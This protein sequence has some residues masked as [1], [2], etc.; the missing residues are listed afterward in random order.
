MRVKRIFL[1]AAI[2]FGFHTLGGEGLAEE[3][4]VSSSGQP[5]PPARTSIFDGINRN[6][7]RIAFYGWL[8]AGITVNEYGCKNRYDTP[9]VS[10][11]NR[12]LA[13]NSGNSNLLMLEQQS[14]FKLNQLWF[15]VQRLLDTRHGFDWGFQT[16]VAYGTDLRYCQ[17]FN[18][19]TFDYDWGDGDYYLSIVSL[20]GD[21]GY[22][23]LSIRAG[24]FNSE[25][26]NE[27]FS[28]T[29]TFFYTKSYAFFDAP[30]VSGVR[31]AYQLN[32][33]WTVLGAWTA[34]ENTSLENR[35]DDNGFLFQ[36]R[37]KPSRSTTLKYS[38]FLERNNGL[39]KRPDAA[40][41]FG[42]NYL[43]QDAASHHAVFLWDLTPRWRYVAEGFTSS[44]VMSQVQGDDDTGFSNGFNLN[45]FYKL[46]ERWSFGGRYEWLRARNTLYD[47]RYLTDAAGTEI[48]S[49]AL[50]VNWDPRPRLNIRSEL[51][52]DWTDYENG[53]KPFDR[54][55]ERNQLVFGCAMT[56]K[57]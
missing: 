54:N 39:N 9:F 4:T 24:K 10:P 37:C 31:A 55:A 49:L 16:D 36:V 56:L 20:Y 53:Y 42:R 12:Q 19:R 51:R 25:M 18:D 2:F 21:L 38:Y 48:N 29:E 45:L 35:F 14:D 40:E 34:G 32:D 28:A 15:G 1:I 26:S 41:T 5:A 8:Q 47:L 33:R 13:G 6:R 46:N 52:H 30:T 11:V 50:A 7:S 44:R 43:T 22:K 17:S 23:N 57:F 27:S 3:P